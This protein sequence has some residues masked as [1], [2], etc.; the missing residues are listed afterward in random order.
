MSQRRLVLALLIG[1]I[2]LLSVSFAPPLTFFHKAKA[3]S[4]NITLYAY[5]S[6]WSYTQT[7]GGNPTITVVQGDTISFTLIEGDTLMHRLLVDIDNSSITTDCPNPGPDECSGIITQYGGS[8]IPPFTITSAPGTYFYYCTYHSPAYMVGKFV[9]APSATPDFNMVSIPSSLIV[10]QDSSGSSMITVTGSNG[11]TGT[12]SLTASVSPGGA[13]VSL[14]PQSVT[15]STT[16]TS[17]TATLTATAFNSGAYSTPV[18]LGSYNITLIG[19]MGSLSHS[20]I[21]LLTMTS[22]SSG[23]GILTS[24]IVIGGIAAAIAVVAGTVYVLRRRS[25]TKS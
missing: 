1:L 7:S 19:T 2:I 4:T 25:K 6:G 15:L 18:S 12:V 10:N 22:P 20:K 16:A 5:L 21:I 14:S 13:T 23:A 11:F 8:S 3:A 17:A 9:V 24:P